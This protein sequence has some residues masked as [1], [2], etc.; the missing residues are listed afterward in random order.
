TLGPLGKLLIAT[1]Q[2]PLSADVIGSHQ[3]EHAAYPPAAAA[4]A[5]FGRHLA[6]ICTGCHGSAFAGGPVPG[7]DPSWPPARNLTPHEDG[8]AEWTYD[9]F[10]RALREAKRPDGTDIRMPMAGMTQYAANMTDTEI[11]ALWAYLRTVPPMAS[12]S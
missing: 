8:L 10:V 6:G 3:S 12:G 11:E 1:D 2:L 4:S 7:G 9:D 5:E